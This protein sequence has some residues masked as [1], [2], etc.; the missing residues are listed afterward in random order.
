MARD[1]WFRNSTWNP[2][3]EALFEDK[4]RRARRKEQYLRIQ[5]CY[6]TQSHP[7][8][9]LALLNRFFALPDQLDQA[10][11][12][13]DRAAALITLGRFEDAI[14]SYEAALSREALFPHTDHRVH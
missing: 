12:H 9:A 6:L 3:I 2:S 10:Q 5:A 14:Q 11:A 1:D 13:V 8:V 7:D 4:L